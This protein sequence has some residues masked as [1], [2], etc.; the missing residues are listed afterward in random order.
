MRIKLDAP[1]L[2]GS[3]VTSRTPPIPELAC[4]VRGTYAI[5]PGGV[6]AELDGIPQLVQGPL[7]A[8]A[9]ADDD[10]ERQGAVTYPG[11]FADFKLNSEV[12]FAGSCHAPRGRSVQELLATIEIGRW[13]KALRVIGDRTWSERDKPVPFVSM[14]LDF[15]HSYGGPGYPLNPVGLGF[16]SERMPNIEHP[17]RPLASRADRP[18]PA[19][20]AAI[21]ATWPQRARLIGKNYGAA[22]KK[23]RAPFYAD[24]LDWHF[25]HSGPADQQLAG[26]LNGD[27]EIVLKNLHPEHAE[28]RTRLPGVRPRAFVDD[29]A[30]NARE[31]PLQLDT[32]LIDGD[33]QQLVLTWRGHTA[34]GELD[35]SDVVAAL[36]VAERLD[37]QPLPQA[38]YLGEL[39]AYVADP[40]G[41]HEGL[42]PEVQKMF[43]DADAGEAPDNPVSRALGDKLA[44]MPQAQRL[45]LQLSLSAAL[46]KSPEK[47]SEIEETILEILDP[48]EVPDVPPP[49][50]PSFAEGKP[51]LFLRPQLSQAKSNVERA[52]RRVAISGQPLPAEAQQQLE[53]TEQQLADPQLQQIDPTWR[54][55]SDADLAPG[56]DLS[57]QD[58]SGRNLS[59][60]DLSGARLDGC[61]LIGTKLRGALVE[62]ASLRG[63]MLF[64]ADLT[65]AKLDGADL[66]L[67]NAANA[68]F[69]DAS[70]RG[71]HLD[72]GFF[73]EADMSRA[74]LESA[75][76]DLVSLKRA[77]LIDVKAAKLRLHKADFEEA[78]ISG[79][80]LS[81][82]D[83][84]SSLLSK[85]RGHGARLTGANLDRSSFM[86]SELTSCN[87]SGA[88]GQHTKWLKA[89][90]D[91]STFRGAAFVD[92][93]FSEASLRG[94]KLS[95]A[96]FTGSRFYRCLLQDARF[97]GSKLAGADLC[98]AKL[99]K[100][101]FGHAELYDAKLLHAAG[102]DCNFA[103]AN[104]KRC[105]FGEP[106]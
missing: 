39:R 69:T 71:A 45:Q 8:E 75:R 64:K 25:F 34:I 70:L 83:I 100:T 17:R 103:G 31:V 51:R 52:R 14:P 55:V 89:I 56:A 74:D 2:F 28:L 66:S 26:Y 9:F 42:P 87:F 92:A 41:A 85:C 106:T 82:A 53:A 54:A 65:G 73:Q 50:V 97:V 77:K 4:V 94:A 48:P 22:Y 40:I 91:A 68:N 13:S 32:L 101:D 16:D 10:H 37:E 6:A 30:G 36:V 99:G 57:G 12:L 19:C 78:D 7:S 35:R 79:A 24:D 81:E 63:A 43:E 90:L 58:L 27:E 62:R 18:A 5:V 88:R 44:A 11:D 95:G 1:L 59:G 46:Q 29:V 47:Q 49:A 96:D 23:T 98:F 102:V 80:D 84:S 33:A 105:I 15:G 67:C 104:L 38:K 20:F 93:H 3:K 76:G 60:V 86:E 72:D 21:S 61:V